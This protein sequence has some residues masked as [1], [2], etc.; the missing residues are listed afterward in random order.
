MRFIDRLREL[1]LPTLG[2]TILATLWVVAKS[3]VAEEDLALGLPPASQQMMDKLAQI[4]A[5]DD[6]ATAEVDTAPVVEH[7]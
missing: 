6:K 1:L 2:L 4:S 5:E 7:H 3:R